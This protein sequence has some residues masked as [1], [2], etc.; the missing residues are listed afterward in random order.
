MA[1][2]WIPSL[3]RSLTDDQEKVSAPGATLGQVM[4]V[5]EQRYP[6]LQ[7]RLFQGDRLRPNLSLLV[8]GE[9]SERG[10]LQPLR[11]DSE[12]RFIPAI[13]GGS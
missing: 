5:L 6:G 4:E 2:M 10:L 13:R 12:I 7:Q 3:L 11:E 1:V 9:V 8:D